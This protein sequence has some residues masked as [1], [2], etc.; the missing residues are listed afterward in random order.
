MAISVI[1]KGL[2][3]V[4]FKLK[5]KLLNDAL[6]MIALQGLNIKGRSFIAPGIHK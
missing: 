2:C 4:I 1:K 3:E 5:I 6:K